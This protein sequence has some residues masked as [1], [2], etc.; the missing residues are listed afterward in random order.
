MN[1]LL[2]LELGGG[3]TEAGSVGLK[4]L[5]PKEVEGVSVGRSGLGV[6]GREGSESERE[7][8]RGGKDILAAEEEVEEEERAGRNAETQDEMTARAFSVGAKSNE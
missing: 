3:G 5:N 8:E 4:L 2:L 7:R 6:G 1:A